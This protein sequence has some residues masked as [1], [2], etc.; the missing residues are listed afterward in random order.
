VRPEYSTHVAAAPA[1][2]REGAV[3]PDTRPT[4]NPRA[5]KEPPG[6]KDPRR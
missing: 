1:I 5:A 2:G 6:T 3:M 4:Y